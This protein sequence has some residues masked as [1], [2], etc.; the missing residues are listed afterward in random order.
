[1]YMM[2]KLFLKKPGKLLG[3][4]PHELSGGMKQRLLATI[5]L[6]YN[7]DLIIADEPTK[8][9]DSRAKTGSIELFRHVKEGHG[10]SMLVITHD[11]DFALEICDRVAVMYAG[12]VV[13]IGLAS[14]VLHNPL[15]PY[16]RGLLKAL[17]RNGLVPLEGQSPSSVHLPN[18]CV[19]SERCGFCKDICHVERPG[20]RDCDGGNVRCHL[21]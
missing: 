19:F 7:P 2:E 11:L 4:Y 3:L 15:H 14:K 20:I 1:M 9:L 17:P 8:G 13:E 16:T 6:S 18:G 21:Y 10:N 5:C 12:E